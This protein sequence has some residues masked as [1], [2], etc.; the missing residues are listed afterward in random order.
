MNNEFK[1]AYYEI[2][3]AIVVLE[4]L[5]ISSEFNIEIQNLQMQLQKIRKIYEKEISENWD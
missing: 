4:E 1:N 2:G 3:D 5:W